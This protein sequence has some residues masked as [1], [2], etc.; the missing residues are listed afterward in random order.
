M[1][2][3]TY[4][5]D[6]VKLLRELN[7]GAWFTYDGRL[8]ILLRHDE[9]VHDKCLLISEDEVVHLSET[10]EVTPVEIAEI[11]VQGPNYDKDHAEY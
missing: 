8:H 9:V 4:N 10:T 3:V 11:I 7:E 2:I 5:Q 1:I 6:R